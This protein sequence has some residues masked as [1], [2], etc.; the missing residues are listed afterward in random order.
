[1]T[2]SNLITL[3]AGILLGMLL[4]S[5]LKRSLRGNAFASSSPEPKQLAD[6]KLMPPPEP[7]PWFESLPLALFLVTDDGKLMHANTMCRRLFA[8]AHRSDTES[9][10]DGNAPDWIHPKDRRNVLEIF[11]SMKSLKRGS[12]ETKLR[13]NSNNGE[14][15]W[16][17]LKI[18]AVD[19][20][21]QEPLLKAMRIPKNRRLLLVTCED[22]SPYNSVIHALRDRETRTK[23][24]LSG[25]KDAAILVLCEDGYIQFCNEAVQTVLGYNESELHACHISVLSP[26][27]ELLSGHTINTLALADVAEHHEEIARRVKKN[28]QGFWAS[29]LISA[30]SSEPMEKKSY[31]VVIRDVSSYKREEKELHEWKKRFEQLAE[32]VKE[33]FWIYDVR[34]SALVY[35]SPVFKPLID[36]T[37]TTSDSFFSDVL[38]K[39]HPSDLTLARTFFSDLTLG[40][41]SSVE[42]R[43]REQTGQL[44]WIKFKSFAVRDLANRVHR[45]VGVAEDVTEG[46]NAQIAL[47]KAKEEADAANKAKSEFLANMSHEIRTPLG[48]IMGF[49][50]LVDDSE[51]ST[52]ERYSAVQAILRN[53]RQLSKI[54]DEILDLSKVEAGRLE[55]DEEVIEPLSFIGDVTTLLSLQAR[56]KAVALLLEPKGVLPISIR[57]DGTKLRQILINIIGNAIKFTS[58]GSVSIAVST[59]LNSA[60]SMLKIA[61]TDTGLGLDRAQQSRLFQPFVQADSSTRR[62]FG[63]TGLGLVLS[64]KLAQLLGGDLRLLWSTPDVGSSF[65][66]SLNIGPAHELKLEDSLK[67]QR[68]PNPEARFAAASVRLDGKK[69]LVVDDAPDNRLIVQRF[70]AH[71]G[72]N[73]DLTDNGMSGAQMALENHYDLIVMDIQM[74][75]FDGYQTIAYLRERGFVR[76]VV[77]LS[78]HAMRE[79]KE[80]SLACGFNEHLSKPVNRQELLARIAYLVDGINSF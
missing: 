67:S 8:A 19:E 31:C 16:I 79:D 22:V 66:I 25:V 35:V 32:N 54:I 30:L 68:K 71:A 33:A 49:A 36:V 44:R 74:P 76:P 7:A 55:I 26:R 1:M 4:L 75:E 65:E 41:D 6:T 40:H 56:E 47:R 34:A 73:V 70:L 50:E 27:T 43:V 52:E 29:V 11:Q 14:V 37:P 60:K 15:V 18:T 24:L 46:K 57:T 53:G 5:A 23:R 59:E 38:K 28:G 63:G 12:I 20:E 45:I 48:A 61:V 78:A 21:Q 9:L 17:Q 69:I 42:F 51:S 62:R 10:V 64:R 77:A 2:V 13:I 80:R 72:A 39:I 3:L 58:R